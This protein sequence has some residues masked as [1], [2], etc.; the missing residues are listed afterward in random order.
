L[1]SIKVCGGRAVAAHALRAVP[2]WLPSLPEI[3]DMTM[4]LDSI[5]RRVTRRAVPAPAVLLALFVIAVV[6]YHCNW[7]KARDGQSSA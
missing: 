2:R 1:R 5:S 3:T 4:R 7:R 6:Y